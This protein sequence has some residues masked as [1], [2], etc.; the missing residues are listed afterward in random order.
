VMWSQPGLA[1]SSLLY[2]DGH[3]L[4]LSEGGD[5]L[6]VKVNPEKFEPLAITEQESPAND[7]PAAGQAP[8]KLLTYPAW[9]APILSHGLLYVRDHNRLVCL[10]LI[11][12]KK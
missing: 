5:L 3:F 1:R 2:A 7:P 10:E 6:L 11:A 4:L 9:A 8:K 12:E